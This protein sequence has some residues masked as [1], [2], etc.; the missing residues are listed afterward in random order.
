M[1]MQVR[2]I[3]GYLP[4]TWQMGQVLKVLNG[5][6]EVLPKT[7]DGKVIGN[8]V[9][10]SSENHRWIKIGPQGL[11]FSADKRREG[12]HGVEQSRWIIFER[13][14]GDEGKAFG[15][16]HKDNY[17]RALDA[18]DEKYLRPKVPQQKEPPTK[19]K[20]PQ[21]VILLD[22]NAMCEGSKW[23]PPPVESQV[24]KFQRKYGHRAA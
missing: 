10:I 13:Q 18:F 5:V 14:V 9:F 24:D 23:V 16:C 1:K 19:I 15:W 21:P 20:V 12:D 11:A 3:G 8:P 7:P 22:L 6:A 2:L 17:R 4:E